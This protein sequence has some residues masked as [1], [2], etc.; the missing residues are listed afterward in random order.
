MAIVVDTNAA[1]AGLY[2][3]LVSRLPD[4]PVTRARLDL[5]DVLLSTNADDP[6]DADATRLHVERKTWADW[7]SSITGG[8]YRE[9]KARFSGSNDAGARMAYLIEGPLMP[10]RGFTRGMA[11]KAAHAALM[12]TSIR[13]GYSVV[14][15]LGGEDSIDKLVYLFETFVKGGL[16]SRDG[17][18]TYADAS[19]LGV[20]KKRKRENL[21]DPADIYRLQLS[22]VPGMSAPKAKAVSDAFPSM[23]ALFAAKKTEIAGVVVNGRRLGP[24]IADR[25]VVLGAV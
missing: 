7:I 9:Q 18:R 21:D 14:H 23:R 16:D 1:E 24:A 17:K 6:F 25:L 11:N 12:K 19:G 2:A 10:F 4:V 5:G 8:R 15:S 3:G 22:V 13:D 20:A